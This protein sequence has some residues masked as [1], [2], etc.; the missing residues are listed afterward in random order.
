MA[1]PP[2]DC[3]PAALPRREV[4]LC[5][6]SAWWKTA[7]GWGLRGLL[8]LQPSTQALVDMLSLHQQSL[9][10]FRQEVYSVISVR[11]GLIWG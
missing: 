6:L 8:K 2:S 3:P 10:W 4:S 11:E 9:G 1:L 7:A 5:G